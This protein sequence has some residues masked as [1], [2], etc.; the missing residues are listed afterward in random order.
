MGKTMDT[1]FLALQD[2]VRQ[3]L[4]HLGCELVD[5]YICEAGT[6]YRTLSRDR[7]GAFCVHSLMYT[8]T[9]RP[10]FYNGLYDLADIN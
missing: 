2:A 6:K 3:E 8:E 1:K 4:G 5:Y 10:S 9:G 7:K